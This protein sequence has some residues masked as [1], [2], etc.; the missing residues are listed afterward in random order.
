MDK[1][2]EFKSKKILIETGSDFGA[3]KGDEA[4]FA[5]MV[6]LFREHI[7]G[8]EIVKFEG[9]PEEIGTRYNIKTIYSGGKL[10][11]RLKT[12]WKSLR[13]IATT[14][15]YVWGGGQ[16]LL[17]EHGF[18]SVPYRLSRPLLARIFRRPVMSYA[19][20]VGP[21]TGHFSRWISKMCLKKFSIIT[22]R[23][24]VSEK[25]LRDCG[26]TAPI[27]QTIDAALVLESAGK[28]RAKEIL[29]SEGIPTDKPLLTYLPWGPAF[30]RTKS[31]M[32]VIFRKGKAIRDEK[33]KAMYD[34]HVR[35]VGEALKMVS[36]STGATVLFIPTDPHSSHGGDLVMATDIARHTRA[37]C[38]TC[39]TCLSHTF[40]RLSSKRD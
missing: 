17:D 20:G 6:D 2:G 24:A 30:K 15:G 22:V 23:D 1:Q 34:R 39:S 21:L 36:A 33:G 25:I 31:V 7:P 28:L 37:T 29:N 26:V 16:L 38:S 10:K 9:R 27:I 40:G 14:N 3:N 18:I 12:I 4:Y 32:P 35:L 5:A 8:I 19:V 11:R 13:E